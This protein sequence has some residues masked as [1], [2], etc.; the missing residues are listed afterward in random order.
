[1]PLLTPVGQETTAEAQRRKAEEERRIREEQDRQKKA[2]EERERLR[3]EAERLRQKREETER[4]QREKEER[5]RAEQEQ[6]QQKAEETAK[7]PKTWKNICLMLI[8][9][10]AVI[11]L[12]VA[13]DA[14]M[15]PKANAGG[16]YN[17]DST[18]DM[19]LVSKEE[20][21]A[22]E[23]LYIPV[24][25][26]GL[27]NQFWA[28]VKAGVDD[29]AADYGVRTSFSAPSAESEIEEQIALIENE[30]GRNPS[31]LVLAVLETN[32]AHDVLDT[33]ADRGIPV[34]GVDSGVPGDT[35][36]AVVATT[37]TNNEFAAAIVAK[38]FGENTDLAKKMQTATAENPVRIA[39][40]APE[41]I[42]GP[43]R[44]RITSFVNNMVEIA[45]QYG[46]VSVTGHDMWAAPAE[47]A[48]III[49]VAVSATREIVDIIGSSKD[50]LAKN[51]LAAVFCTDESTVGGFLSA[52]SYGEDLADGGKYTDLV[53][54][55]F[56]A[57][58]TLKRA[59]R[60]GWFYGAVAQDPYL[61][62]YYAVEMAIAAAT[63]ESVA[64]KDAGAL[65]YD[66]SNIDEEEVA[67]LLY[68]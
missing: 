2:L 14:I 38:K 7:K 53:V 13:K 18:Q 67:L 25:V 31:A 16:S 39:V 42:P 40:L 5:M 66:A 20:P 59:I 41:A 58:A 8:A 28:A 19:D 60:E 61:M 9:V 3:R 37:C 65:W 35:T 46:T 51:D 57:G 48:N 21:F 50:L 17:A 56:G 47:G 22:Y 15:K 64:D 62:G 29:A 12:T 32:A 34:I 1:M 54:A 4:I 23:E 55:G 36:G 43:T 11:V 45:S 63:G 52:A 68:D 27:E 10:I 26:R 49:E 24:V 44:E 30:I 6:Q 33:C